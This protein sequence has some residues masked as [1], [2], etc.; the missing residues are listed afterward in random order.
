M[1]CGTCGTQNDP[2]AKFCLECG[3]PMR[4]SCVTCGAAL[5]TGAK[6]CSGCGSPL[7]GSLVTRGFWVYCSIECAIRTEREDERPR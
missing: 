1:L 3:A 5:T 4:Q 6:F 2:A 7:E